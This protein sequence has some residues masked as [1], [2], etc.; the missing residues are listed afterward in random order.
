LRDIRDNPLVFLAI[1]GL[2]LSLVSWNSLIIAIATIVFVIYFPSLLK[3]LSHPS[4]AK[5]SR[6]SMVQKVKQQQHQTSFTDKREN[7]KLLSSSPSEGGTKLTTSKPLGRNIRLKRKELVQLLVDHLEELILFSSSRLKPHSGV[8]EHPSD[9]S[10]SSSSSPTLQQIRLE[11]ESNGKES[12]NFDEIEH[13]CF[14][15][16]DHASH[17]ILSLSNS[18]SSIRISLIHTF[19]SCNLLPLLTILS[20]T[21]EII[22]KVRTSKSTSMVVVLSFFV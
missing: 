11:L 9:L 4:R 3:E 5:N 20:L 22:F 16:K 15:L 10:S 21:R 7:S 14:Q 17:P 19:S 8:D 2:S 13:F 1:L 12:F 6:E 18:T